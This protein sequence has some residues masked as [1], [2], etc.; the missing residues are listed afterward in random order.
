MFSCFF[1]RTF[2]T[3]LFANSKQGFRFTSPLPVFFSCL[4]HFNFF[5]CNTTQNQTPDGISFVVSPSNLTAECAPERG[6]EPPAQG[7]TLGNRNVTTG[8]PRQGKSVIVGGKCFCPSGAESSHGIQHPGQ[9]PGLFGCWP[10]RP[11]HGRI[12]D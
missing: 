5:R 1:C 12:V 6:N 8:M 2:G 7:N 4:R 3:Y 9:R 11:P 10:S